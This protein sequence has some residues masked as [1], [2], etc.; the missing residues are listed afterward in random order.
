LKIL[1]VSPFFPPIIGGVET[2][3]ETTCNALASAGH[4][5]QVLTSPVK[6]SPLNE[7][8]RAYV[9]QRSSKLSVPED[10][11]IKPGKFDFYQSASFLS[12]VADDFEPDVVHFHNYQMRQYA[13]FLTSF[14]HGVGR[15]YR[16]LN[17]LHNDADDPL[18]HYFLSYLP[19][20]QVVCVTRKSAME[21]LIAGV[22]SQKISIVP[23]MIDS[24]RFRTAKGIRLRNRLG[25]SDDDHLILF[26]SR[27]IGREGN[28]LIDAEKGKGLSTLIQSLSEVLEGDPTAKVLLLGNDPVFADEIVEAKNRLNEVV[29]K[30]TGKDC[31]LFVDEAIPN[32]TMPEIFA[33][34]DLVVSLSA[35]ETFGMVFLEGMSAGKPVVGVNSRS[36]GVAEV[37][38]DGSA[39]Y[40]VPPNDAHATAKSILK[41]LSDDDL[42]AQ[43]GYSGVK[44]VKDKFDVKVVLPRLLSMYSSLGAI[45]ADTSVPLAAQKA[46]DPAADKLR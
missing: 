17:T 29:R 5:V 36:G 34:S 4:E 42:R 46:A 1:Y 14:L 7:K 18:T 26:P 40:L 19:L 3:L 13:M 27:I 12:E 16:T 38:P 2:V 33:A 10:G 28:L 24:E 8:I 31:L 15:R 32:S 45:R 39:G 9:V 43:F 22:P 37:F 23:N 41:I 21:L 11:N 6:G 44:W 20:D 25:L 30:T 35:R